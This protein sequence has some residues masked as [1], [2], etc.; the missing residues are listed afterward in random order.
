MEAVKELAQRISVA[1]T[2]VRMRL[3][4]KSS[5]HFVDLRE[6][7]KAQF[8][9]RALSILAAIDEYEEA[10]TAIAGLNAIRSDGDGNFRG[11]FCPVCGSDTRSQHP[12]GCSPCQEPFMNAYTRLDSAEGFGTWA[13]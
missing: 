1:P 3:L 4:A 9:R 5:Q 7:A 10:I 6:L 13:I 8:A 2:D 12:F 11:D